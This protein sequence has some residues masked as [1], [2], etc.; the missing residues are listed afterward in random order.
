MRETLH[1]VQEKAGL[2]RTV[3]LPIKLK[4]FEI[5]QV[6]EFFQNSNGKDEM[7][8]RVQV[9]QTCRSPRHC[10]HLPQ[11]EWQD[12]SNTL[13]V[14]TALFSIIDVQLFLLPAAKF[15]GLCL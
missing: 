2:I 14:A 6:L 12:A 5:A 7:V 3:L 10:F 13:T 9:R 1:L 8:D 11:A 15:S 4:H